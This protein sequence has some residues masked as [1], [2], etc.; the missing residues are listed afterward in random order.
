MK[1]LIA[2]IFV[3]V[4]MTAGLVATTT[5]TANAACPYTS[6]VATEVKLARPL[7]VKKGQRAHM[8]VDVVAQS[9]NAEPVG[10]VTLIVKKVGGGF[11][12]KT[13]KSVSGGD[14][15]GFVTKR[16]FKTG[17]YTATAVYAPRSG[18]VFKGDAITKAFKVVRRSA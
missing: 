9:G 13:V 6:C 11:F 18:S 4:L 12:Q 2:S 8:K 5:S 15:V 10:R 7:E 3:A 1:K 17:R 14:P 16:L